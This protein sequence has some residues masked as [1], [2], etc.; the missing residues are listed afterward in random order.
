MDIKAVALIL[1]LALTV[2]KTMWCTNSFFALGMKDL[3]VWWSRSSG[4]AV[5]KYWS[6]F[7]ATDAGICS[8][9]DHDT[10]VSSVALVTVL[11]PSFLVS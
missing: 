10:S 1:L 3:M 5:Q 6:S 7:V 11:L 9:E 2:Y 8:L 4:I